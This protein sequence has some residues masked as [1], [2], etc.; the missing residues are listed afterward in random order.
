VSAVKATASAM[1]DEEHS[2]RRE[3]ASEL[4]PFDPT[5]KKKKKKVVIQEPSDEVDKLAEKTE[6]LAVA[7]PAELNFTGMKK[8]KK[9]PVDLDST[10]DELGDGEDTQDDQAVEEQ[11]EGIVLGSVP[12]YPWEGTDRDYKYEELLTGCSTFYVRTTQ[13]LLGIGVGP[14]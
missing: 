12:T 7:E 6:T 13:I 10:L 9:K 8:K 2:E 11:G 3:E 5:K 1:A 4:A 14:L